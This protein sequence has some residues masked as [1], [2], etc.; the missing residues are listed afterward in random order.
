MEFIFRKVP[1]FQHILQNTFRRMR[2][3]NENIFWKTSYFIHSHNILML[4]ETANL[5]QVIKSRKHWFYGL[6]EHLGFECPIGSA[7][8]IAR[9][10]KRARW[11]KIY[12]GLFSVPN[13]CSENVKKFID[14]INMSTMKSLISRKFTIWCKSVKFAII[15]VHYFFG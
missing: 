11:N 14:V 13:N 6:D 15:H 12:P 1:S 5:S 7:S 9:P 4:R 2:L 3:K 8:K 10:K